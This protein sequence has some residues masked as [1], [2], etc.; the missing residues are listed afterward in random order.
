MTW[1]EL[2]ELGAPKMKGQCYISL[3]KFLNNFNVFRKLDPL[4]YVEI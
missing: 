4:D 2:I 1:P 3:K